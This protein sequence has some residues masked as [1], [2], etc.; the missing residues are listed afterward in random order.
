MG[1]TGGAVG[2]GGD[3]FLDTQ[4]QPMVEQIRCP[5]CHKRHADGFLQG[6]SFLVFQCRCKTKFRVDA[7]EVFVITTAAS[8]SRTFDGRTYNFGLARR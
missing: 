5:T 8:V 6:M 1:G 4:P 2:M 7:L 3:K